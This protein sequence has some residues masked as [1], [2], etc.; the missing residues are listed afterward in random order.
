MESIALLRV[1]LRAVLAWSLLSVTGY[2][3]VRPI[4]TAFIPMMEFM[5]DTM[6]SDFWAHLSLIDVRG[7]LQILMS[8]TA[9]QPFFYPNGRF[10]ARYSNVD[11][12][13]TDAVHALVPII[14]FVV[15]VVGWPAGTRV[16]WRRRAI[17]A[18]LLMPCVVALTT[19]ITLM[20]LANM[21]RD[22]DAFNGTQGQLTALMQPF[23]VMEM[24]GRWLVPLV[25]AVVC[26][27]VATRKSK[28]AAAQAT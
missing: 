7:N 17:A 28:R 23:A 16:E 25:A 10:V 2:V 18:L 27:R 8:C 15:A 26:I 24:G 22:P 11:C 5:I 3:F 1:S 14:I 6:Q 21:G 20:G 13:Y 19:P 4:I 12:A 9:I